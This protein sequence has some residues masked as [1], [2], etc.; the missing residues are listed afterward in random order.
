M[1]FSTIFPALLIAAPALAAEG[2]AVR[3]ELSGDGIE[4]TVTMT[5]T[6]SGAVL[7]RID[8]K[9]VPEG[10]HGFHVHETGLCE[11]SFESAGGHI[12]AGL[13]HGVGAE[14]GPHPGDLPNLHAAADGIV[15]AEFF[16]RGFSLG[17]EGAE[18]IRD[19]DG[20]AV[21]LHADADD[22]ASQPSGKAGDRIACGVL[23]AGS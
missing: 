8:A 2:D 22:Y 12:A 18:R 23:E 15:R 4:G 1:R 17:T 16:T 19:D 10:M 21:I 5:E 3:A 6:A 14:G 9:G 20:S 13:N 7:V 11:G